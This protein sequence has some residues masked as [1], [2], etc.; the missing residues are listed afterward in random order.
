MHEFNCIKYGIAFFSSWDNYFTNCPKNEFRGIYFRG[1]GDPAT[2]QCKL[3]VFEA[4]LTTVV[5]VDLRSTNLLTIDHN[6]HTNW[7]M[8]L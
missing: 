8:N 1:L 4:E 5:T 2:R 6:Y 7:W 3:T